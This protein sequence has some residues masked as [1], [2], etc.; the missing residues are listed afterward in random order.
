MNLEED[1]PLIEPVPR[2]LLREELTADHLVRPTRI[3]NNEVYIFTALNA[4]NLMQEVGRLREL[5]FRDAGAGFGTAVDIDHFDTNVYPCKQLI[6]WDPVAEEIIGG[7]RFNIFNQFKGSSLKD[8]P[9][10]NKL[11]YNFSNKFITEYV[12]YL[13]ELTHAFIQPKYQVK[14]VGR[15]AAFSL[16]NIWDGLGALVLKYSFIRYFFGRLTFFSNYDPT[17]RDFAF[18]FFAKHLQG[19]QT[20]IQA[21]E[22]FALPTLIAE[23]EQVIDGR[24]VEE[25][26]KK[27][28]QAAKNH[29]T[30]IPPLVKSYFN[31]SGTMRVFEPVFD[32]YF[33]S[34][35]ATAI[36]VT[37]ADIYPAF[38]KRY[39]TPY[40]RYLAR[41]KS[42]ELKNAPVENK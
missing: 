26:Y 34:T 16:D 30:V 40:E 15:K 28:N 17:V 18:Y 5:T 3:G 38:I 13:V 1:V 33:C 37:I 29:G 7:Y 31:V 10:A 19:E 39:I 9:L 21:K 2:K 35:Y 25:D 24:S 23:L 6:V 42:R 36:M 11:L 8:I 14:H 32:P 4:P 22:P 27:L 12:P 20:L 41:L